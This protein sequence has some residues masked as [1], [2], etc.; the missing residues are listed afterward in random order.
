MT[1]KV[2]ERIY[3]PFRELAP[4]C[5]ATKSEKWWEGK[6]ETFFNPPTSA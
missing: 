5:V 3:Y 2:M 6:G 1:D 4:C